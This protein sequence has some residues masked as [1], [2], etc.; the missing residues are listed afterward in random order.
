MGTVLEI[1]RTALEGLEVLAA[2]CTVA[3]LGAG[4]LW[5]H[6]VADGDETPTPQH[7]G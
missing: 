6:H 5:G 3:A 4:M 1:G 7:R 2:F